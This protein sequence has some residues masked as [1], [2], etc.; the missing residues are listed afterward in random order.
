MMYC[1]QQTDEMVPTGV[2]SGPWREMRHISGDYSFWEKVVPRI[3]DTVLDCA[4]YLYE[5]AAAAEAGDK[6]SGGS[7]FLIGVPYEDEDWNQGRT[8]LT[9]RPH[10]LYAVTNS[11][12]IEGGYPVVRLNNKD[13]KAKTIPLARNS[14]IPHPNRDDVA[15]ALMD[16]DRQ[17]FQFRYL[18]TLRMLDSF[19]TETRFEEL[20]LGAGDEIFMVGRFMGREE[21]NRNRPMVRFGHMTTGAVE[22]ICQSDREPQFIQD[23]L[24]VEVHSIGG[25]S[26]SPVFVWVPFERIDTPSRPDLKAEFRRLAR[27]YAHRPR[28]FLLGIDWGHL[29]DQRFPGMAG[30]VPAWKLLELLSTP[31][32]RN[33]RHEVESKERRPRVRGRLDLAGERGSQHTAQ[34]AEIPIPQR[35]DFLRDLKKATTRQRPA[36]RFGRRKR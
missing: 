27:A 19:I 4:I 3:N 10:H 31:E 2:R 15:I 11:H 32:V 20:A 26:G 18:S 1:G 25:L 6:E 9:T 12:V 36:S 23:S 33:M 21:K 35:P 34:D 29:D 30:V 13:G 5:S 28:E 24:L 16:V 22:P 14:W 8:V 7:G 17:L